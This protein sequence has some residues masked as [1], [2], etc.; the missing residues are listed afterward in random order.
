MRQISALYLVGYTY[1]LLHVQTHRTISSGFVGNA[2]AALFAYDAQ[3]A[4]DEDR[5]RV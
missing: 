2:D 5:V 3:H 4:D 1:H